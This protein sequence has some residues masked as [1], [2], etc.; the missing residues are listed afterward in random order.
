MFQKYAALVSV[1]LFLEGCCSP[2]AQWLPKSLARLDC[3]V[4][5]S[6][7]DFDCSFFF[8]I[9]HLFFSFCVCE[10]FAM[11]LTFAAFCSIYMLQAQLCVFSISAA[12]S[13][14]VSA[15][16]TL[17]RAC[18]GARGL[19]SEGGSSKIPRRG[20]LLQRVLGR[21][22]GKVWSGKVSGRLRLENLSLHVQGFCMPKHSS[23][24]N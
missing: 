13:G 20:R 15:S 18:S 22:Y 12:E 4:A 3:R 21:H 9:D 5:D 2:V 23:N 17:W 7:D 10:I 8:D 24:R 1:G 19:Q 11:R 16:I 14:G 6:M